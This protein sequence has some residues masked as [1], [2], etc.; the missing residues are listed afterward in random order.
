MKLFIKKPIAQLMAAA[1]EGEKTL[2]RT[3]GLNSLIALGIG[4]IIG[5]GIFVRTA[6]AAGE[7]AGPAVTISFI[8]AA[9]GCALAGLCYAE[10]ASMIP[11]AGSA[12]TYSYATM[13]ELVAWIIGWDLVLEYALGAA[14]VAIGWAQYFND[15]LQTFFGFHIPFA[16]THSPFETSTTTTGMYAA[17]LGSHGIVN[18]PAIFILLLLTLLLIRGTAESAAVNNVIVIIKVAIVLMIIALGWGFINPANHTPYLIPANAPD[19]K[20]NTGIVHYSDTFNHGWLGVLRGASVV[21]F[22]FIG[23]DAVSTAAQEAKNPQKDMPKGILISLVIC[24]ALY[25]LFSHVLTGLAPYQ[26]FLVQGKEASVS[27]AIKTFMPGYGWLAKLVTV[28]ILAGFSSV[29]L[30]MLLGQT[31]VFYTMSTDGLIPPVFSKLHPKHRTP[32][33]SQ[34]LFFVFVSLFAGFIP[35]SIVGEMVS[36]GTLFAFVL[37]CLGIM[38][39]RKTDPNIVRPFKTPFYYIVCPL[40]AVICLCMMASEGLE[41]WLRLFVW[42]IIGFVIYFGYSIKKSH[43]RHGKTEAANDPPNPKFV[44]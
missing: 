14:T 38:I 15:F 33:K 37:V 9:A 3:L 12:Y 13:G 25:I 27:F 42:L 8:I 6:A 23:F 36:I 31:R 29:I 34:W 35:D 17:E 10:F 39:L 16:L 44:E 32:Y 1:Q 43:V 5:A 22:A 21:F 19:V 26:D 20:T 4:A 24:T 18:L 28:A 11:I 40:G 41:N 2:K 7:H 30:V